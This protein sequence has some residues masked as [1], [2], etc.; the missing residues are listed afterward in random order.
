MISRD[1]KKLGPGVPF[2][3]DKA[4]G[5][6]RDAICAEDP[7]DSCADVLLAGG[8]AHCSVHVCA[9]E[10][11][12]RGHLT[13]ADRA[14]FAIGAFDGVHLGHRAL[15]DRAA[16]EATAR[17]ARLVVV[18]FSPDPSRVLVGPANDELLSCEKR[19]RMLHCAGAGTVTVINFTPE[20]AS[21]SYQ[22]FVDEVLMGIGKVEAIVVGSDFKLGFKGAGNVAALSELGASRG[23]D[24]IGMELA[25]AEG[26]PITAT[27]VR[28]LLDEGKVE[29]AADLLGRCHHVSGVVSHGRGE[30]TT[31][32]FP[33]ANVEV[34]DG[35]K[36]P[37]EGVYA[38]Y[39]VV[40]GKAW[41]SAVNVGRPRTFEPGHEG[42]QFLE[43]TLLG[44]EGDLYGAEVS[45]VFLRWLRRPRTF[46]SADELKATVLSNI[47]WVR[48]TL[49]SHCIDL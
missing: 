38:C 44:F 27:R 8:V 20:L 19:V 17:G 13:S 33:T 7:S 3:S 46:S 34:D 24:V 15:L 10:L 30:G 43:A 31:F 29:L 4:R 39:V 5:L 40:G 9:L 25:D 23:F 16:A 28:G 35:L 36:L 11:E 14:V 41:P 1:L 37:A 6:I 12:A 2:G 49:S 21:L 47:G 42:A 32:G 26:L 48:A 22:R 45:V 18:T